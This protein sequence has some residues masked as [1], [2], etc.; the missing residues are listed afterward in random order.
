MRIKVECVPTL[1]V[2]KAWFIVPSVSTIFD[3][4]GA[5]CSEIPALQEQSIAA[6]DLTLVLDSFELLDA[7]PLDVVR[8]G[9]HITCVRYA[10]SHVCM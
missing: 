2:L 3:L 9:D 7:S 10:S 8:D 1:P 6:D 4:K 5:I